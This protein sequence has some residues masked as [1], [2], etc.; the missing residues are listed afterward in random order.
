MKVLNDFIAP[1]VERAISQKPSDIEARENSGEKVNFID[2][3]SVFTHDRKVLR[4]QLVST[5]LASRDTTACALS[6]LF[7]ELAYHPDV[8]AK[9]RGEVLTTL[10]PTGNPT[11]DDLKNMKY[12]QY[13]LNESTRPQNSSKHSPPTIPHRSIQRPCCPSRYL[14]SPWW[15]PKWSRRTFPSPFCKTSF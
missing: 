15:W 13:C 7:Y 10:G 12:M 4:D 9:L 8:Y 6:W 1:F 5:L 11:Y 14:P 2:S 3:L